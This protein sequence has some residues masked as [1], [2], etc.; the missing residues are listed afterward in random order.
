M[1]FLV[2][3]SAAAD[4]RTVI[5]V[6]GSV[7]STYDMRIADLEILISLLFNEMYKDENNQLKIKIYETDQ[8]LENQ[9][10]SGKL[11]ALFMSPVFFLNNIEYLSSEHIYAVQHGPSIKSKYILLVRRDSGI[12][13]LEAL[14]NKKLIVPTGHMVGRRY[15]DIVLMRAGMP[16]AAD[17]FSEV[18][19]TGETNAAIVNLFFGQVDAAL[20]T[21]FSFEVASELNRQ[22]PQSLLT[23]LSSPPLIHMVIG[24][25]KGFSPHL[26]EKYLPFA[27]TL[28]DFPRLR[29]L[30]K[31]FRFAGVKKITN[32]DFRTLG[33]LNKEYAKLKNKVTSQ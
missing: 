12:D 26:V 14:R 20:V 27:E 4:D 11:D 33:R 23:S 2:S 7:E 16:V 18:R 8:I 19:Y 9:L 32:D 6:G 21:D 30:K 1:V 28:N 17:F 22:I 3:V 10:T 29:Y 15:L 5:R 25:R 13:S 24:M 31:N